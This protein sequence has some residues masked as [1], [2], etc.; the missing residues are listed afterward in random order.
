[1]RI[2]ILRPKI[3]RSK[4]FN[5]I[6]GE[7]TYYY[8]PINYEGCEINIKIDQVVIDH[9]D[10]IITM[11]VGI[12]HFDKIRAM[13]DPEKWVEKKW[14]RYEVF[15]FTLVERE[16][17]LLEFE[18]ELQKIRLGMD[19]KLNEYAIFLQMMEDRL[20]ILKLAGERNSEKAIILNKEILPK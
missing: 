16:A 10:S 1:M 6:D 3:Y 17:E 2:T 8:I 14:E 9:W 7:N 12:R 11:E 4:I 13:D 19:I 20:K 5:N 18:I 15:D